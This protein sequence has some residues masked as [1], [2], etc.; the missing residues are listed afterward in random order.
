MRRLV[1]GLLALAVMPA[2]LQPVFAENVNMDKGAAPL[3]PG[4]YA[5]FNTNMGD[6]VVKLMPDIAPKTVEN[7]VGLAKGTIEFVDPK[8]GQ[9]TTHPFYNG[10][11]FHRVIDNFMIQGGDPLGTGTGGPGYQFADEF[12]KHPG[13]N[14]PGMLAMAN[15]GP[16]TNG[17]QFFITVVPTPHLNPRPDPYGNMRGHTIFGAVVQGYDVVEKISKVDVDGNDRPLKPVII[18][19]V[20]IEELKGKVK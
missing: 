14:K 10:L 19:S 20:V 7:F 3:G 16:N 9:K 11:V 13:F 18:N 15:A 6:F 17:S 2:L 12:D 4:L 5:K 8:T 1:V